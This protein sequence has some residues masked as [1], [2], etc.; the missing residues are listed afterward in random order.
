MVIGDEE[1]E[2]AD[3]DERD[4]GIGREEPGTRR[5]ESDDEDDDDAMEARRERLRMLARQRRALEVV[6]Q[7]QPLALMHLLRGENNNHS[8]LVQPIF[9]HIIFPVQ[10]VKTRR[11]RLWQAAPMEEDG[12]E[13][14][15]SPTPHPMP[16]HIRPAMMRL[17][18]PQL[19]PP[20][21]CAPYIA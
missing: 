8:S 14:E 13:D 18:I 15:V 10:F 11:R 19:R 2:V 1:G 6:E 4:Y 12:D 17:V 20:C 7:V 16:H 3:V 9:Y 5:M 21:A